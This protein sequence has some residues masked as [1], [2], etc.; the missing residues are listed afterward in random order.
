MAPVVLLAATARNLPERAPDGVGHSGLL[1]WRDLRVQRQRQQLSGGSL[2]DREV[3][4]PV[5]KAPECWLQVNGHWVVDPGMNSFVVQVAQHMVPARDS[6]RV[7]MPD[8]LIAGSGPGE[9]NLG[10]ISEQLGITAG[11]LPSRQVAR[12]EPTGV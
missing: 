4:G 9:S 1:L 7:Q 8:V 5:A 6:D 3:A 12:R 11:C 10:Q 2:G